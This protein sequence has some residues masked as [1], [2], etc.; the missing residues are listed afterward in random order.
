MSSFASYSFVFKQIILQEP[1]Q[2]TSLQL[3][4]SVNPPPWVYGLRES[5]VELNWYLDVA[6]IILKRF[7]DIKSRERTRQTE[8]KFGLPESCYAFI[9]RA[10][11][12]YG[13]GIFFFEIH[14][15]GF[16]ADS[17]SIGPFDSG[18]LMHGFIA[19]Q[20]PL[21]DSNDQ[22]TFFNSH[23][24]SLNG[25]PNTFFEYVSQNY[26][27]Y[28]HYIDGNPPQPGIERVVKTAPNC[29]VAWTWEGRISKPVMP[30]KCKVKTFLCTYEKRNHLV[31]SVANLNALS[32]AEKLTVIS[33]IKNNCITC[34]I[35]ESP[36]II[37]T[38]LLKLGNT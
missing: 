14:D 1:M 28:T 17:G 13:N 12:L 3:R 23:N 24:H 36:V 16:S 31:R 35:N 18:G 22:V 6:L 21:T 20:P 15:S 29:D 30:N 25:W 4:P 34:P 38:N 37:A 26:S 8:M 11:N 7:V 2:D 10:T 9:G 33:W 5:T 27:S 19:L 32:Q